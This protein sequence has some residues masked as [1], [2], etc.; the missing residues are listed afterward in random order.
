MI[1]THKNAHQ[2]LCFMAATRLVS[3]GPDEAEEGDEKGEEG[4]EEEGDED[5][6][7][8]SEV[9]VQTARHSGN[10]SQTYII[11]HDEFFTVVILYTQWVRRLKF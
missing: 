8:R 4:D 1:M 11:I 6:G 5:E 9:Q 10:P 3:Y 7:V 2:Y